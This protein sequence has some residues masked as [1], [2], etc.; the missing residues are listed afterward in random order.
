MNVHRWRKLSCIDSDNYEL[1]TKT[2]TLLKRLISKTEEVKQKENIS[3][4]KDKSL[5]ELRVAMK[6]QPSLEEARMINTFKESLRQ[7]AKQILIMNQDLK[8]YQ[9]QLNEYKIEIERLTEDLTSVK[10]KYLKQKKREQ[11]RREKEQSEMKALS[12]Q[13]NMRDKKFTGGG[14]NLAV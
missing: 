13:I 1:I 5:N 6:R 14:F 7:K 2:Q 12:F 4:D 11:L 9:S 8:E 3:V 10:K